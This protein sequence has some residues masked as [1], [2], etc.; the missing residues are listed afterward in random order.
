MKSY[1]KLTYLREVYDPR[2]EADMSTTNYRIE[3]EVSSKVRQYR[4][5]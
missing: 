4:K 3:I 2:T 1:L 5:R